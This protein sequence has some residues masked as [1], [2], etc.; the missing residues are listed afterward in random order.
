MYKHNT[1]AACEETREQMMEEIL[2]EKE[3]YQNNKINALSYFVNFI[4]YILHVIQNANDGLKQT[5]VKFIKVKSKWFRSQYQRKPLKKNDYTVYIEE[6]ISYINKSLDEN[7][8]ERLQI[9][10][11]YKETADIKGKP[12][13]KLIL[14]E[15]KDIYENFKYEK[16]YQFKTNPKIDR[17]STLISAASKVVG[18]PTQK[19][20]KEQ[21]KNIK[22][23]HEEKLEQ[24]SMRCTFCRWQG[25]P[26]KECEIKQNRTEHLS[27]AVTNQEPRYN[28]DK[29]MICNNDK[30]NLINC[31]ATCN[32]EKTKE[33]FM[34]NYPKFKKISDELIKQLPCNKITSPFWKSNIFNPLRYICDIMDELVSF[35]PNSPPPLLTLSDP[36]EA[37]YL[38]Q[39][40][41][42]PNSTL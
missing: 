30:L 31:C 4:V 42:P 3:K 16:N 1:M 40:S 34:K 25:K 14:S 5:A 32:N 39:S 15:L 17:R 12:F 21:E 35:N 41:P 28:D 20:S 8:F 9:E 38:F 10:I 23:T 7:D 22:K 36:E 29:L 33:E 24:K 6:L 19:L 11:S 18:T 13:S 27:S 2:L 37:T 26:D